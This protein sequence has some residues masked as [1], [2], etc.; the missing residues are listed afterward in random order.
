MANPAPYLRR[1]E[2]RVAA[3][4][5]IFLKAVPRRDEPGAMT[6]QP[7]SIAHLLLE[8]RRRRIRIAPGIEQQRM[9]ALRAHVFVTTVTIGELLVIMLAEKTRQRVTHTRDR[10][11]LGQVAGA[12]AA[13][14][15]V[16]VGLFEDVVVNVMAPEETRQFS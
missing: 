8:R 14:P 1:I 3:E 7:A 16:P 9:P 13:P 12:A 10:P 6:E 4:A 15:P 5:R 11:I 2:E